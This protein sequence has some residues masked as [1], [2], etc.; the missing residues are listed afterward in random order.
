MKYKTEVAYIIFKGYNNLMWVTVGLVGHFGVHHIVS[1][2][3]LSVV[4]V[5]RV[6]RQQSLAGISQNG[7]HG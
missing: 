5:N 6:R 4:N 3:L 2:L 7:V 1:G